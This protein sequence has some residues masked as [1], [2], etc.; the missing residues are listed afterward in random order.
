MFYNILEEEP[1][2]PQGVTGALAEPS[3]G[4]GITLLCWHLLDGIASDS[5]S[6]LH[7]PVTI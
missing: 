3:S 2:F 6:G 5:T 1:P 7:G 4:H